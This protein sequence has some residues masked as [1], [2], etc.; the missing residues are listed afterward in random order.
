MPEL[1][2]LPEYGQHL[3]F[4]GS[5]GSGKT[6]LAQNLLR[7]YNS[8]FAIDSQD[9]LEGIKGM[10]FHNPRSIGFLLRWIKKLHYIPKP[11]YLEREVFDYV[12][13]ELLESSTK[14][15]PHPR[16]VYIDEIYH[17][18]YGVNFPPWL[19]KAI[20]T[21]R[22]RKLSFWISTQRPAQIPIP[23]MSEATRMYVYMLNRD[24]D[25]KRVASYARTDKKGLYIQLL[26][27]KKDHS[28]IEIDLT[29]GSWKKFP[30]LNIRRNV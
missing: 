18:G 7:Y 28:F 14:R 6:Y 23:I 4:A 10:R 24:E 11:E 27:Q 15:K 1:L 30:P 12:F 21:A 9:S 16:I 22:Q 8:F 13:R 19:P 2:K 3:V 17:V 20:T 26:D 5:T 25:M 29:N